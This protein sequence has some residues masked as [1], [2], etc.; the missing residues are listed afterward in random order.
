M[1]INTYSTLIPFHRVLRSTS[2]YK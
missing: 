1:F 2:Q